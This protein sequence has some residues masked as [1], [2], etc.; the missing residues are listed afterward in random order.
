M[1]FDYN[2]AC[3]EQ[4]REQ[5]LKYNQLVFF[6]CVK[7]QRALHIF[8]RVDT[9][10]TLGVSFLRAVR[11]DKTNLEKL[12][13]SFGASCVPPPYVAAFVAFFQFKASAGKTTLPT[14][15]LTRL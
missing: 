15:F 14:S 8:L 4:N 5:R 6:P 10:S 3:K 2:V 7:F 9:P 13:F 12:D 11:S 1:C